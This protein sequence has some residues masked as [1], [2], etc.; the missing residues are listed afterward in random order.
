M[1]FVNIHVFDDDECPR[2]IRD[3]TWSKQEA[4]MAPKQ[5][6]ECIE[7][8]FKNTMDLLFDFE[9]VLEPLPPG[10]PPAAERTGAVEGVGGGINPFPLGFRR[11]LVDLIVG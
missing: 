5:L 4:K 7:H 1:A 2:E 10:R 9:A 3:Q 6:P 8:L 11:G